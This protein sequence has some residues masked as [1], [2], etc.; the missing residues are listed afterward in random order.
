MESLRT[1][2][3]VRPA[4]AGDLASITH[5]ITS[6]DLP[7]RGPV[8]DWRLLCVAGGRHREVWLAGTGRD[9]RRVLETVVAY[10][11]FKGVVLTAGGGY[12][13]SGSPD[14]GEPVDGVRRALLDRIESA[15]E[16]TEPELY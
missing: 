1:L 8:E 9:G 13:L 4:L 12:L 7:F 2:I 14:Y 15:L 11:D 5:M 16:P 10:D 3:D 6:T